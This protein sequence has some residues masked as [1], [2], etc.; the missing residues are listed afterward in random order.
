VGGLGRPLPNQERESI[1]AKTEEQKKIDAQQVKDQEEI[2]TARKGLAETVKRFE[3]REANLRKDMDALALDRDRHSKELEV[4]EV[5]QS[6]INSKI[7]EVGLRDAGIENITG[8]VN[9]TQ[10]ELEA[11]MNELVTIRV[12]VSGNKED[13]P[14]PVPS[15]NGVNQPI[16][17]GVNMK[18]K[19]KYVEALAHSR[20][21]VVEQADA[22][23]QNTTV[24]GINVHSTTALTH[25]F[26][27]IG[28]TEK[29]QAW[30]TELLAQ[31]N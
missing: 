28:D 6:D 15:V 16:I 25:N 19:R 3:E 4:F 23:T 21:D 20:I 9:Q 14:V 13:N 26:S 29:G 17:L 8:P 24:E 18:V 22:A 1:M 11:F 27:T 10:I 2:D 5:A 12:P 7:S 30:L 31:P